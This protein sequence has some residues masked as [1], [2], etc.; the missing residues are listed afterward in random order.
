MEGNM[1]WWRWRDSWKKYSGFS[2][3][4]TVF[5]VLGLFDRS[6]FEEFFCNV[7]STFLLRVMHLNMMW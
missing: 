5:F 1:R 7:V 2:F 3:L 4:H 6:Q